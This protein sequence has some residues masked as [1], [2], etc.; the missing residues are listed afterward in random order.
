MR[1]SKLTGKMVTNVEYIR[2]I[3]ASFGPTEGD[4]DELAHI[5]VHGMPSDSIEDALD[6]YFLGVAQKHH[7]DFSE[8]YDEDQIIGEE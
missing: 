3:G 8:N 6:S 1:R 7:G 2:E 5:V 4:L